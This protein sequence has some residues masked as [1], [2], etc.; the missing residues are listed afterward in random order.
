MYFPQ[1]VEFRSITHSFLLRKT[2]SYTTELYVFFSSFINTLHSL[3]GYYN[4]LIFNFSQCDDKQNA[5][6]LMSLISN[7][8]SC[9]DIG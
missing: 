4:L 3:H 1:R 7:R 6:S 5:M 8:V 2:M 9:P